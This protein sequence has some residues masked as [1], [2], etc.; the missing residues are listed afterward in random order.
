MPTVWSY[1]MTPGMNGQPG[2]PIFEEGASKVNVGLQR[3][4]DC[5]ERFGFD[6]P[7][8]LHADEPPQELAPEEMPHRYGYGRS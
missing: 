8:D 2:S 6:K 3:Y 1:T 7:W 4:L 5:V